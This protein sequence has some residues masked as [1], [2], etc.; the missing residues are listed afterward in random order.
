MNNNNSY[1]DKQNNI[2]SDTCWQEYKNYQNDK[3]SSYNTYEKS[4]QLIDCESPNVRVPSFMLDHPNLRGR[5]GFGVADPCLVDIYNNLIKNDGLMTRDKCRV[6]LTQRIFTSAPQLKG[7]NGDINKELDVLSGSDS[8]S[9]GSGLAGGASC[10]KTIMEYQFKFPVPLVD[11]MKDI[12]NPDNIVPTWT[13]GGEDTRSY[14]NRQ[15]F[16]KNNF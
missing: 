3:I 12:Q 7:C 13:N 10:K 6:Q 1:Y 11:A 16:N 15:S 8:S 4:A 14:A 9:S 5:A 2:C